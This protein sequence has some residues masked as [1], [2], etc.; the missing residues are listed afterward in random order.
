MGMEEL[1]QQEIIRALELFPKSV[2]L[3]SFYSYLLSEQGDYD[4]AIW[5]LGAALDGATDDVT[6]SSIIGNIGDMY[7]EKGSYKEVFR[8]YKRALSFNSD[9]ALVLN[10]YA[11]FLSLRNEDLEK[12]LRMAERAVELQPNNAS[13]VDTKA[14]VL[15]TMGRNEEAKQVM[16]QALSLSSMQDASL[17][18]HYGDIL[19]SLGEKFM[20]ETYWQK[21]VERGYDKELMEAHIQIIKR[22]K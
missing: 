13:Y 7:H 19:W 8:H 3:L 11:Y 17:L 18:M 5:V 2:N 9:N 4:R 12:A 14:W 21:A 20:A 22:S 6:K 16:R 10:N 1:V 15:H